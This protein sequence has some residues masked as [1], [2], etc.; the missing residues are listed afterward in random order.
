VDRR[1]GG[2]QLFARLDD[3]DARRRRGGADVGVALAR[4]VE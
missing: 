4:G 2:D 3:D 1:A